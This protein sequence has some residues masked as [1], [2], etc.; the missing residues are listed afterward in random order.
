MAYE[1]RGQEEVA[2]VL[3]AL[4]ARETAS[5]GYVTLVT[6]FYPR[7]HHKPTDTQHKPAARS[8]QPGCQRSSKCCST[9]DHISTASLQCSHSVQ[10][11]SDVSRN[12]PVEQSYTMNNNVLKESNNLSD[13]KEIRG[14]VPIIQKDTTNPPLHAVSLGIDIEESLKQ[15]D[16]G[17][18]SS[19]G[20]SSSIDSDHDSGISGEMSF[21]SL[22]DI[23]EIVWSDC[24][25]SSIDRLSNID[26]DTSLSEA[27]TFNDKFQPTSDVFSDNELLHKHN[28]TT[29]FGMSI[30][31]PVQVLTYTVTPDNDMYLGPAGFTDMAR[32][33]ATASGS[34]GSNVEYVTKMAEFVRSYIPEDNDSYLFEL[35]R[36]VR[37]QVGKM[38]AEKEM[39]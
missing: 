27:T 16:I 3:Q 22:N 31:S 8:T 28:S 36:M 14:N 10:N 5:G 33:I 9:D 25:N 6:T 17:L 12:I 7:G 23:D 20:L 19:N 21:G 4:Y 38:S 39:A 32:Q 29:C 2:S 18:Y 34:A 13:H 11:S 37:E 24:D 26:T 1:I 15:C 30:T 35:D